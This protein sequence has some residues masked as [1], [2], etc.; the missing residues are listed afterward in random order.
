MLVAL[1][2]APLLAA[3]SG[4]GG[5]KTPKTTAP[6]PITKLDASHVQL[7]RASFCDRVSSSGVRAALGGKPESDADWAN[8]DPL[9]TAAG[10]GDQ[11]TGDLAHEFGCEWTGPAGA[12]A[13]AWVFARP[14]DTAYATTLVGQ[15][16]R[17]KGCTAG[18]APVLG[19]PALV[20]TCTLAGGVHRVRRAGLFADTWLSCEVQ[21]ATEAGLRARTDAWCAAVV[22][23]LDLS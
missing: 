8:G 6:T 17:T 11:D 10:D 14:V 21:A 20:Q 23:A 9:P 19:N 22:N 12:V 2:L 1:A 7:A 16:R 4:S 5:A 18:P 3:C 13:R 15:A